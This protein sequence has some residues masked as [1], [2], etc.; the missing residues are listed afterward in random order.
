MLVDMDSPGL[1]LRPMDAINGVAEFSETFLDGGAG[2]EDRVIGAVDG[3]WAVAMEI[4]RSERGGIFWMLSI[5]LLD[6]LNNRASEAD[7]QAVDD[8]AAGRAFASIAAVRASSWTTQ[9]RLAVGARSRP[10]RHRSTR[11]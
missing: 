7:L 5:W 1:T 10:R 11:S 4:L 2:A 3:G 8:E 6:E 9:H